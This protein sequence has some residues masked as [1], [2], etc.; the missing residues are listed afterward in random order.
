MMIDFTGTA[1]QVSRAFNTE[2]HRLEVGGVS[3]VANVRDPQIPAA[4]APAVEGIVSLHDFR[5]HNKMIRRQVRADGKQPAD[6]GSCF[7]QPCY[8]VRRRS[9]DDL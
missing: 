8:D 5:P 6:S 1:G 7:G 2:I 4:L 3:H 9:G